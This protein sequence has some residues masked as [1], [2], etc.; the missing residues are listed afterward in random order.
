MKR[1]LSESIGEFLWGKIGIGLLLFAMCSPIGFIVIRNAIREYYST[2]KGVIEY[3][4][5]ENQD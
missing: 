5:S 4:Y 3:E 1:T 2:K